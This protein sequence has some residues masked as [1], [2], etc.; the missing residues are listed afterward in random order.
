MEEEDALRKKAR[1]ALY[2]K[3][4]DNQEVQNTLLAR[5]IEVDIFNVHSAFLCAPGPAQAS[6]CGNGSSGKVQFVEN[7]GKDDRKS[8][9]STHLNAKRPACHRS[10]FPD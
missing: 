8:V 4:S 1:I 3:A 5:T 9:Q 2:K 7:G 10:N 6:G